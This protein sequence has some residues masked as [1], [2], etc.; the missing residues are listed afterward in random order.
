VRV[1]LTANQGWHVMWIEQVTMIGN[2]SVSTW[3]WVEAIEL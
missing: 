3:V 1:G 2:L